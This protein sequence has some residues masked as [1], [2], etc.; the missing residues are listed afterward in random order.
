MK[1]CGGSDV[2]TRKMDRDVVKIVGIDGL[3]PK[4]YLLRKIDRS[5]DFG[6]LY[7]MVAPLYCEENGRPNIDPV[8]LF[9][10]VLIQPSVWIAVSASIR[11]RD[12]LKCSISVVSGL[13]TARRNAAFFYGER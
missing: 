1:K 2:K 10:M 3:V 7:E 9:K 8:G 12:Q 6:R 5:V 13:L 11:R 4:D